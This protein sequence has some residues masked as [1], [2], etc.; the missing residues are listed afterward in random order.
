MQPRPLGNALAD[1]SAVSLA[2]CPSTR[3]APLART[4]KTTIRPQTH[5]EQKKTLVPAASSN[6]KSRPSPNKFGPA[7]G[8]VEVPAEAIWR[9]GRERTNCS[10]TLAD[11]L[12]PR[13]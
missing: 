10:R 3:L 1:G 8:G 5:T 2:A 12:E 11:S 9:C 7:H 4:A 6:R 13:S